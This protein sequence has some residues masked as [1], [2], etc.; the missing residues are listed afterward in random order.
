MA[1]TSDPD[2]LEGRIR[3]LQ[4]VLG[5]MVLGVLFFLA[6]AVLLRQ[7]GNMPPAPDRPVVTYAALVYAVAALV[8]SAVVPGAI[9]RAGRRALARSLGP[10]VANRL[11]TSGTAGETA[12]LAG[13]LQTRTIIRAAFVEAAAFLFLFAYLLDDQ[14]VCLLGAGVFLVGLVWQVPTQA[15]VEIWIED[16]RQLLDQE[17]ALMA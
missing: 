15:W 17:R 5:A 13:L 3:A 8:A 4:I 14:P 7:A 2:Q 9:V 1:R 6:V 16:Q 11:P 10:P 12:K